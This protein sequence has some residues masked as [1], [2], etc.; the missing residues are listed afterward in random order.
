[1]V[2]KGMLVG[3]TCVSRSGKQAQRGWCR[4]GAAGPS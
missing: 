2:E 3:S 1:M 4:E